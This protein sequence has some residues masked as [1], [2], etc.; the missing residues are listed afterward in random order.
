MGCRVCCIV[1]CFLLVLGFLCKFEEKRVVSGEGKV[2]GR[3]GEIGGVFILK[4][5]TMIRF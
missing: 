1:F 4:F 5:L 3:E 2:G